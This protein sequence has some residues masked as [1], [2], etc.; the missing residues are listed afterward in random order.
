MT[1]FDIKIRSDTVCPWCY[2]G[3][4]RLNRAITLYKRVYP[5]G[6]ADTFRITH[7]PYYLNPAFPSP[8]LPTSALMESRMGPE[9]T[10]IAKAR[11]EQIGMSEGIF[12]RWGGRTGNTRDSHR[13]V[14]L[15]K[16]KGQE[17][18]ETVV[19]SLFRAC[20]EEEMD[21][22]LFE[23][24]VMCGRRA[25][26]EEQEVREWLESGK[27]GDVVDR[28]AEE[29]SAEGRGV[30]KFYI[31]GVHMLEGAEDV[32][33]FLEVFAKIKGDMEY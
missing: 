33:A 1:V 4:R 10:P 6:S 22:S 19:E 12:F 3:L 29:G 9:K 5:S 16:R 25:G 24:L 28:E 11:M 2:I 27:G 20:F 21:V 7:M 31:Q 30:P 23:T 15:A 8:G 26:L 18:Q 17:V 14:E 32:G 13:L